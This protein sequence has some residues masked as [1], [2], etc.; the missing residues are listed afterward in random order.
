METKCTQGVLQLLLIDLLRA[1]FIEQ[2]KRLLNLLY[3]VLGQFHH[4]Y[5][6]ALD[7]QLPLSV[8][9]VILALRYLVTLFRYVLSVRLTVGISPKF[10]WCGRGAVTI[11]IVDALL[12]GELHLI[13][14]TFFNTGVHDVAVANDVYSARAPHALTDFIEH[15]NAGIVWFW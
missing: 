13:L 8:F 9:W 10:L 2:E 3:L 11:P 5:L 14:F 12:V 6:L 1:V 7:V 4:F 15:V